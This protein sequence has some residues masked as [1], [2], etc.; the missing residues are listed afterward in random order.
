VSARSSVHRGALSLGIALVLAS[1][2]GGGDDDS[3]TPTTTTTT[4]ATTSTVAPTTITTTPP[5]TY[6]STTFGV[7]FSADLPGGWTAAD[8]DA[9]AAQLWKACASCAQDGEED[10]EITIGLD[11]QDVALDE[12][13][14]QLAATPRL[15]SSA[16]EPWSVGRLQGLHFTGA[17]SG[18]GEVRF[19]GGYHTE[20]D[21]E[22]IEVIVLRAGRR[23][24]TILVDSHKAKGEAATSFHAAADAI[25]ASL[26]FAA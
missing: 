11:L 26:S 6:H 13:A 5:S 4:V 10:G 20:A 17:R 7:P 22:P 23:T 18:L 24:V 12:A 19:A 16:V 21:A 1:C 2:S 8:R 25:L 9:G 3:A 14:R 15:Q